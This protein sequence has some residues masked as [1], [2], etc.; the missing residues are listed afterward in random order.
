MISKKNRNR[1]VVDYDRLGTVCERELID[2]LIDDIQIMKE[3][4]GI[5]FFTG[6]KLI[7]WATNEHGE[8]VKIRRSNGQRVKWINTTHY[9]P[10][11]L[12]YDL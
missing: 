1:L 3:K 8:P 10:A 12:D 9:R 6:A 11:C 2:A 7:V 5:S 4:Y